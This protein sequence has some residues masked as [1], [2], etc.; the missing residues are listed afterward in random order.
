MAVNLAAILGYIQMINDKYIHFYCKYI[1]KKNNAENFLKTYT[2]T[3]HFLTY[4]R[5]VY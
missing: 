2:I 5:R 4:V 3:V 1:F